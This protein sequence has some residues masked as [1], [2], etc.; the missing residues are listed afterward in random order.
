MP[1]VKPMTMGRGIK[2]TAAPRPVNPRKS[3]ITPAIMVTMNK[4]ESPCLARIPATMTTNAPVG[5][6]I[7]TFEP[8]R[9]EIRN[10]PTMAV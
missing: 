1:L 8:P 10:P 4:P 2:R 9:N 5:P 7:W 6:P 3:K